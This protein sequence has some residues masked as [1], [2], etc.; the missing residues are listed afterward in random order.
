[1]MTVRTRLFAMLS[2]A[3]LIASLP[4]VVAQTPRAESTERTERT[5]RSARM[6]RGE[7][8]GVS[9][10]IQIELRQ[11]WSNCSSRGGKATDPSRAQC[12]TACQEALDIA[13]GQ[14]SGDANAKIEECRALWAPIE[15]ASQDMVA[16]RVLRPGYEWM[17][18]V[19]ATI[20]KGR[21]GLVVEGRDGDWGRY[22]TGLR[23][24]YGGAAWEAQKDGLF[25]RP[26]TRVRLTDVQ[27]RRVSGA[28]S[29]CI[30]GNIIILE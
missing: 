11:K 17:P 20:G 2:G 24:K 9:R 29:S 7:A 8:G 16:G 3:V 19:E 15:K 28:A 13:T 4:D 1:M 25:K 27:F 6:E 26:G 14:A 12:A 10:E 22:C 5:T 23:L 30:V 18:A 21:N